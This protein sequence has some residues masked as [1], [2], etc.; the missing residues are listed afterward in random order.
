MRYLITG[1]LVL[2]SSSFMA[3]ASYIE[4]AVKEHSVH[5]L[6]D[7]AS[8]TLTAYQHNAIEA[9]FAS[10]HHRELS[11]YA[12][13]PNAKGSAFQVTET[14]SNLQVTN[15]AITAIVDK[16]S[17]T[18]RYQRDGQP[19]LTQTDFTSQPAGISFSFAI[20]EQEKLIGGGQRV[21][22]MDRR[23]HKLPLYNKAHYGYTTESSQMYYSLPAVLSSKKY[24]LLFDNSATGELDLDSS[25]TNTVKLSA[26]GGRASYIV[27]AD[28]SYPALVKNYVEL[29]GKQPLPPRWSLGNFASR[30]GYHN[31]LEVYD[32]VERFKQEDMPLDAL[33]L[34][35]YWFGKDIKG[36]MGN[37]AWDRTAFPTPEKMIADLSADG[38]NTVVITEPFILSTSNRWL[39]AVENQALALNSAGEP[40]R[41]DFYFGNTGLVDVFNEQGTQWFNQAYERLA[42]QGVTGWW[43]DLGEPEVHPDDILHTLADGSQ[44]RGDNVHN[45]Y[46][47]KWAEMVY[48]KS[49]ELVPNQRPMVMMRSGFL[50]SQRYGMIP[51]T[52]DVSR[53]WG[54]LKPQVEL[55]LQMSLFGLAYT[56]SDLGGF[57]GGEAF[58]AEMYTRWLQY[59][60]FQPV[61]R[62][63][64]QEHIAPEPVFHD[65]ETK[66]I[67]REFIKLRYR[68][69]P[70]NYT[71]AFDNT[72]TGMPL[73][74]P[75]MFEN[76]QDLSL[77]DEQNT[78]LWG[79][80]FLVTPVTQ[81]G[82]AQVDVNFPDGVWFDYF[83]GQLV[84]GGEVKAYPVSLSSL[85]VFVRAGSFVPTTTDIENTKAYNPNQFNLNYY[86]HD[87]IA[88]STGQLYQD[89]GISQNSLANKAYQLWQFEA[90]NNSNQLAIDFGQSGKGFTG[91]A[92]SQAVELM[93]HHLPHNP[94]EVLWAN[95]KLPLLHSKRAYSL[96]SAGA[97]WD[98]DTQKLQVKLALNKSQQQ[99]VIKKH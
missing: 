65:E 91:L 36:H 57:A 21:L 73:M 75:L 27:V 60:V 97:F 4:H 93:V 31:Q 80:A 61:Y 9:V 12:I 45:V 55:S 98:A 41:F 26:V 71:L 49:L 51:W 62:P 1:L 19:L 70:Y 38:V 35:L 18:I 96:A 56:H 34:D 54:G 42:E 89:D 11:S 6:G 47:H 83:T 81:A 5:I 40:Y 90:T 10:E 17:L 74:R 20:D 67:V 77:I 30:F 82:A 72:T 39:K 87:S 68:L 64:A 3:S 86:Y 22:G 14:P 66:R 33:V 15:G 7:E 25:A 16:T 43:G 46:G 92:T 95:K 63:H 58:D 79:D 44:V 29:T 99:L 69:L 50:G 76:E 24:M 23:G 85:P 28:N 84:T 53:S 88:N 48:Q 52:G 37:L 8:F 59:G 2:S 13:A 94:K 78:Y 32:V